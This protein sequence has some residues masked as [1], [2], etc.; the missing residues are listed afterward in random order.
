MRVVW[1]APS[2]TV[3]CRPLPGGKINVAV[4]G[5]LSVPCEFCTWNEKE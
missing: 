4:A 5:A 2:R 1:S 3:T